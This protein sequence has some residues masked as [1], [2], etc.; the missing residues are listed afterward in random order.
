MGDFSQDLK[1][2]KVI[3]RQGTKCNKRPARKI[4]I[5]NGCICEEHQKE[6]EEFINR[7]LGD[8]K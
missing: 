7:E 5:L 6:L 4:E 2:D 1:C 3:D 8:K